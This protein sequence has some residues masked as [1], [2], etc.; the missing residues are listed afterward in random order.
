MAVK[1]EV[2]LS[3]SEITVN[4]DS[5]TQKVHW[6]MLG[7][8]H[9]G[10][11]CFDKEAFYQAKNNIVKC[12]ENG[13][14]VITFMGDI[15]DSIIVGDKRFSTSESALSVTTAEGEFIEW[16][17]NGVNLLEHPNITF[18]GYLLGNHENSLV[19]KNF[20]SAQSISRYSKGKIVQYGSTTDNAI[21]LKCGKRVK[22]LRSVLLHQT[23]SSSHKIFID[24]AKHRYLMAKSK[25]EM[26]RVRIVAAG[27]THD[28]EVFPTQMV[29]PCPDE[30]KRYNDT[31][32]ACR[33][34]A[35]MKQDYNRV[36]YAIDKGMVGK[37]V[38]YIEAIFSMEP[39]AGAVSALDVLKR[40]NGHVDPESTFNNGDI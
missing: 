32:Y 13:P 14:V 28:L 23:P 15:L 17:E 18:N 6:F 9:I 35:F 20:N 24:Y 39:E 10:H 27:H 1:Q 40:F 4:V 7:D 21:A 34:G 36:S 26:T 38:G 12:A 8:A 16:L 22:K 25:N 19:Q 29:L 30:K 11:N 5:L 2:G 3:A 37:P 31:I 33:T